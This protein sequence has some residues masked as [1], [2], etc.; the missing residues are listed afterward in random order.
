MTMPPN[1]D[2]RRTE[3]SVGTSILRAG[4]SRIL[5]VALIVT[6][7]LLFAVASV[8]GFLPFEIASLISFVLGVCLLAVELEP[9]VSSSLATDGM[10]GYLR[11]LD[12][13]MKAMRVVGQA[14]FVPRGAEVKMV[15]T[16]QATGSSIELPPVGSGLYQE[17]EDQ[18][19]DLSLKGAEF[20]KIW[21]PRTLVDNLAA[22]DNVKVT[23]QGSRVEVSMSRPFV[24]QLC[25]DPFVNA[26]VCCRMGCPLAAA[27][28]QALAAA[29]GKEVHFDNCTYEP[30]S[31][32]AETS[33]SLGKSG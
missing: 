32:R 16:Q 26:N 24:R 23:E 22:S 3:T 31:Q 9:R 17:I 18:L 5:G 12:G 28:A 8:T 6:S 19:G 21:I 1:V 27:M 2:R 33:L 13:T 25:V 4:S 14:T 15:M 29:T 30:K 7:V 20:F 11:S 10:L